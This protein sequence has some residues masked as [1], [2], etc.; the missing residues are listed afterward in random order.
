[1]KKILVGCLLFIVV[2]GCKRSDDFYVFEVDVATDNFQILN[3]LTISNDSINFKTERLHIAAKFN[4]IVT[5]KII[6]QGTL[7][8]ARK[9]FTITSNTVDLEW[10]GSS[11]FFFFKKEPCS[12]RLEVLGKDEIGRAHV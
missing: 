10:D 6:I 8:N 1:M 11:N 3:P 7:S 2:F 9:D 5:C 12:I 4:E